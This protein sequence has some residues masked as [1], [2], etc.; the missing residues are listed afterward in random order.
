MHQKPFFALKI[1][2]S[3]IFVPFDVKSNL[4]KFQENQCT[5]REGTNPPKKLFKC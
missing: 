2:N 5:A 3:K 4:A 1:F